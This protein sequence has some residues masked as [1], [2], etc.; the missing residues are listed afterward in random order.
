M[1]IIIEQTNGEIAGIVY[2]ALKMQG[3]DL[4]N[5]CRDNSL[6]YQ[7]TH[8]R[9]TKK[10]VELNDIDILLRDINHNLSLGVDF[11]VSLLENNRVII[12]QNL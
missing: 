1:K 9:I 4:L 10:K 7:K 6:D 11:S 3:T 5:F 12:N 2:H 8:R